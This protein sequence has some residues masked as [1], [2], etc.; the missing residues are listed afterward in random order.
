MK[1]ETEKLNK[2]LTRLSEK[3]ASLESRLDAFDAKQKKQE[4]EIN[5]IK[6][7]L[8]DLKPVDNKVLFEEICNETTERW[9][10]RQFLIVSGISEHTSGDLEE[11]RGNDKEKLELLAQEMGVDD[12]D[13]HPSEVSRVGRLDPSRPRLLRF[14]CNNA[15][16]RRQL[17][18]NSKDLRKSSEFQGVYINPDLTHFQRKRNAELRKEVRQRRE[19]GEN[20]GIRRGHIVDLSQNSNFH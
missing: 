15:D 9:R 20:V 10:K 11:R 16:T 17:L 6:E 14:K 4:M 18:R 5:A 8:K 19:D 1:D 13:L 12:L 2:A 7:S 3:V